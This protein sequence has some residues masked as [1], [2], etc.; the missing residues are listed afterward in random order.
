MAWKPS[1]ALPR[2]WKRAARLRLWAKASKASSGSLKKRSHWW[3][4]RVE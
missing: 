2:S 3:A 1:L 4:R